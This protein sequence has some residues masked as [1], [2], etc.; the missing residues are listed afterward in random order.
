MKK[1]SSIALLTALLAIVFAA[2]IGVYSNYIGMQIYQ[3]SRGEGRQ[4]AIAMK[5]LKCPSFAQI[6]EIAEK[7]TEQYDRECE[8]DNVLIIV[9]EEDIGKALGQ[10]LHHRI[11]NL[12][13]IICIDGIYCESG[14]FVDLGEPIVSGKVIPVIVKTLIF[15]G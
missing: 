6:Q 10:A 15:N 14:D 12:R 4:I 11:K 2:G 1:R 13:K 8:P 3:E 9:L 5:G 7:L